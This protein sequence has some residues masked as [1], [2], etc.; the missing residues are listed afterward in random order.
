MQER[1]HFMKI[2]F[3]CPEYPSGPHGGIGTFT[4]LTAR[5]L[6]KLGN[7]VRVIGVYYKSYLAKEY[8]EDQG[9]K[10]WR[11]HD[12]GGKFGW[13]VA[14]IKQYKIVK[15]WALNKEIDLVEAPDSR[16]WFAFWGK[17][18]IPLVIRSHGSNS[19]FSYL[20][21]KKINKVSF[22]LEKLSYKRA[23]YFIA[24]SKYTASI[25]NIIFKV[26]I[27]FKIIYN[28]I[29]LIENKTDTNSRE[30]SSK[31]IV[32]SGTLM[33][34]KGIINLI[35]AMNILADKLEDFLLEIYGKDSSY[36]NYGSM[37]EFIIK[38]KVNINLKD[39]IVFKGHV[40]RDTLL[41]EYRKAALAIFPS[42]SEAFAI[43][44]MEA[45]ACGCPTIYSE[46]GSGPELIDNGVDGILIK[47]EDP[48]T[49]VN[50]V[51]KIL[52]EKV[53][54]QTLSDNAIKKVNNFTIQKKAEETYNYYFLCINNFKSKHKFV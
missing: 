13:I 21:G 6:V 19:Y 53:F 8:E 11:L 15:K 16:G 27:D 22:L 43:A 37:R 2:C 5:Y 51:I 14:W 28:G 34:K 33:E 4:Q 10:V 7:E 52:H 39:K 30:Y 12:S 54:A 9:V 32:Y 1:D 48:D 18:K 46:N 24:V 49:I 42:L 40:S 50:A 41:S 20:A 29:E 38:Y 26:N 23:D 45:M 31:K 25:T 17:L 44:P 36:K 35:N 47:P 3:I